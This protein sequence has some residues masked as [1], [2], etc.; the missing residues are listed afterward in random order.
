[1]TGIVWFRASRFLPI[2]D[3]G[4]LCIVGPAKPTQP[5][6]GEVHAGEDPGLVSADCAISF[7]KFAGTVKPGRILIRSASPRLVDT[8]GREYPHDG[9]TRHSNVMQFWGQL[10]A[11]PDGAS[12]WAAL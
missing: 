10:S 4:K 6:P 8:T 7:L 3:H 11:N 1:M 9:E 2:S 12:S 5:S